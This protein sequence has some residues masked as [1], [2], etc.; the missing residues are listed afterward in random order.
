M[1]KNNTPREFY[2]D[3]D[4]TVSKRIYVTATSPEEAAKIA[5]E[6]VDKDPYTY[7]RNCDCYVCSEI[8]DCD[9]DI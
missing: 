8:T 5:Q 4:I 3:F 6:K 9:E 2:V 7:A 1:K